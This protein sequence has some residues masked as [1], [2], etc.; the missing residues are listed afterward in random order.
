[1]SP[2]F[3][4]FLFVFFLSSSSAAHKFIGQTSGEHQSPSVSFSD[5]L[6]FPTDLSLGTPSS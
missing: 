4:T 5:Y 1:M 2:I 3:Y 6:P